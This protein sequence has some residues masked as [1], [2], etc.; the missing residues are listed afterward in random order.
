M[1][2]ME[3]RSPL[4][5][6]GTR[7][8]ASRLETVDRERFVGRAVELA[9]LESC[10]SRDADTRVIHVYGPGGIGKSTLLREFARRAETRGWERFVVEGRELTPSP[11]AL[12]A[13]LSAAARSARPVVLIDTYERMNGLGGYLRRALL[14]SLPDTAVVVIAGRNPPEEAWFQGGWESVVG[15]FE[16]GKLPTPEAL[17]LLTA[18]GITDERRNAIAGWADGSPLALALAADAASSDA[19][20]DPSAEEEDP[21][22]L[23]SLVRR[24]A[25]AEMGSVRFSV[26]AVAAI[27]RVTTADML[28]AVL[29][30]GDA[31]GAYDRLCGLSFSERVGD[32][33]ALHELVRKA[34]RADLRRR[35]PDRDRELRRRI[36]DYLY[37]RAAQGDPLLTIEMAD[38][39]DNPVIRWGFGWEGSIDYRIDDVRPGDGERMSQLMAE[40]GLQAWWDLTARFVADAPDR[41]AVARDRQDHVCGFLV[42]MSPSTAPAFAD[43]DPIVGPRLAHAR[44][45]AHRGDSVLW[46]DSFDFTGWP[47][48]QM[49]DSDI[50]GPGGRV[51]AM[52]GMAGILR[53]GVINPRF[54]YLPVN[55]RN[56]GARAFAAAAGA[57]YLPE[58]DCEIGDHRLECHRIDHGAGGVFAALRAFVYAELGLTDPTLPDP[59]HPAPPGIDR[60]QVR[61]ALRSFHVP[62]QLA[63]SPLASGDTADE[64]AESVRAR[65]RRAVDEAFGET[66]NERLLREVLV[67]GYLTP[68]LNHE[69]TAIALSLSRAAY[70]RRLRVAA[71]RVADRLAETPP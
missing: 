9:A 65:V 7:T 42:S 23:R 35:D 53:S 52:L 36:V 46:H 59:T 32:G 4:G 43:D 47:A 1:D 48:G 63:R 71:D 69:Q 20:W 67:R 56:P 19:E 5:A 21:E 66:P 51:K 30:E 22:I 34:L 38:L 14:P 10:L 62:H 28:T 12:E 6:A 57:E 45:D 17:A 15:E 68:G 11:D 33:L 37:E 3:L 25:A 24:L 8:L 54:M 18:H 64:R 44:A 40:R 26:L 61:D 39:I 50:G 29:P 16:L 49:S 60:D 2:R 70:F 55:P 41:V 58:L 27:A 13:L 31:D